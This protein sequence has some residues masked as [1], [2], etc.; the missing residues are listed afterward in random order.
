MSVV[1]GRQPMRPG[2]GI[3]IKLPAFAG[4]TKEESAS[5]GVDPRLRGGKCVCGR[6]DGLLLR[7]RT[8]EALGGGALEWQGRRGRVGTGA[9]PYSP[10]SS[11]SRWEALRH[12]AADPPG[13]LTPRPRWIHLLCGQRHP[14]S[15]GRARPFGRPSGQWLRAD[16]HVPH[17]FLASILWT[18]EVTESTE[19]KWKTGKKG[20]GPSRR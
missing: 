17:F 10:L 20:Y 16:P 18:T 19:A 1:S 14:S 4:M 8:S 11:A 7:V 2:A 15:A 3:G 6:I 5:I 9:Y 12:G 13:G